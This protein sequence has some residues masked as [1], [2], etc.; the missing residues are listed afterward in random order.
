[1]QGHSN[2]GSYPTRQSKPKPGHIENNMANSKCKL[3]IFKALKKRKCT[4]FK[5]MTDRQQFSQPRKPKSGDNGIV[6]SKC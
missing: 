3:K 2:H 1:M 6:S 4:T 5:G